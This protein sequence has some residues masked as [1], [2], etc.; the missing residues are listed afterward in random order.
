M[1]FTFI[2][3]LFCLFLCTSYC[4]RQGFV[5]YYI[6]NWYWC[7]N[8]SNHSLGW[9]ANKTWFFF[10]F[11]FQFCLWRIGWLLSKKI[12]SRLNLLPLSKNLYFCLESCDAC[13]EAQNNSV[14]S[15]AN[16]WSIYNWNDLEFYISYSVYLW[17][18][19][20]HGNR[21]VY[22]VFSLKKY[23]IKQLSFNYNTN[24]ASMWA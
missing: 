4:C 3:E 6:W 2:H 7:G 1:L 23:E 10:L 14:A 8:N 5:W 13:K 15:F 18:R 22:F 19:A 24:A 20:W 9:W 21:Q 16:R 17:S 12:Q 11:F